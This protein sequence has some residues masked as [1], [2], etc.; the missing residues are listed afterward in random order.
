VKR[1]KRARRTPGI[2]MYMT[3]T[4]TPAGTVRNDWRA[5]PALRRAGWKD[6]TLPASLPDAIRAAEAINAKVAEWRGGG[7]KPKAV[8][9]HIAPATLGQLIA[10]YRKEAMPAK[11]KTTQKVEAVAL[12]R[13]EYW[14]G[15]QPLR[16]ITGKAVLDLKRGLIAP[17]AKGGIGAYPAFNTLKMLRTLFNWATR[18]EPGILPHDHPN[19]ARAFGLS[20]PAPRDQIWEPHET[21]AMIASAETLGLHSI[22]LAIAIAEYT[23][24]REG[25]IIKIEQRHWR[26]VHGLTKDQEA[27]LAS[28]DGRVMGIFLHQGKTNRPVGIPFTRKIA[29]RVDAVFAANRKRNQTAKV[30]TARLIVNEASGL[31]WSE[32][33]FIRSFGKVR[34]HAIA[35]AEAIG[36]AGL[37]ARLADLQFRDYRRTCVVRLG[38]IGMEDGP[39][40]AMT[41]HRLATIK[42]ILEVYMPRTTK[43]AALAVTARQRI[44]DR[45]A[46]PATVTPITAKTRR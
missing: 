32:R 35:Q 13:L 41:G 21:A 26:E 7:A 42:K 22:A 31:P 14:G 10:R 23:G 38:E 12:K 34:A 33:H 17:E 2:P 11:A 30:A 1:P 4:V 44:E 24:Q 45:D 25:D 18:P 5:S 36:D 39:I 8:Q 29:A 20:E 15:D 16:G 27:E 19:P 6:Q 46:P 28:D 43:M 3:T 9:R 40:S 37:A